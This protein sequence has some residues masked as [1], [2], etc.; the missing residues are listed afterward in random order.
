M[1][2]TTELSSETVERIRKLLQEG[3]PSVES[4]DAGCS[5]SAVSKIW[6]KQK[7]KRYKRK[8]YRYRPRWS[9]KIGSSLRGVGRTQQLR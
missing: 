8:T 2:P 5:Q 3:N 9:D 6:D 7:W 4:K 1:A